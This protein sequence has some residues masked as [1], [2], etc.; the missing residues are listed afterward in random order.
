MASAI[1]RTL[2]H[3]QQAAARAI[4]LRAKAA[5]RVD[6]TNIAA[7]YS[8]LISACIPARDVGRS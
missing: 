8:T 1:V 7:G 4:A 5:E 6:W 3:P 2:G